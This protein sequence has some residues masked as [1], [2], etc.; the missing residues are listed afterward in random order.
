MREEEW[1]DVRGY[2]GRYQ[3]SNMG[4]VRSLE[5]S[6]K[7]EALGYTRVRH[8]RVL[9]QETLKSGHKRVT[10]SKEGVVT[11]PSVHRLVALA[12]LPNPS[13]LPFVLHGSEGTGDNSVFNLRWGTNSENMKDRTRD[14]TC[15]NSN[16]THCPRNHEYTP[17]NTKL[18]QRKT[19]RTSRECRK[20]DNERQRT[21]RKTK[22]EKVTN[23]RVLKLMESGASLNEI[24]RQTGTDYRTVRKIDS[25]YR[26]FEAGGGGDAAEIR[27]TNRQLREFLRRGKI[28]NNRDAGFNLRG[29]R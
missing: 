13:Q 20:C 14:G 17:E 2:A 12:F 23:D 19:G 3:V 28:G 21:R 24:R 9:A 26:P 1:R 22:S 6:E 29:G 27:E 10:L 18:H 25:S 5:R 11:R 16:K 7:V 15:V 4:R 8:P